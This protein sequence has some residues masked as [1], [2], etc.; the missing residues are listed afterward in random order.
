MTTFEVLVPGVE[1]LSSLTVTERGRK[2]FI[3]VKVN[4]SESCVEYY[5][6]NKWNELESDKA[7]D[8]FINFVFV[9]NIDTEFDMGQLTMSF[10]KGKLTFKI[11]MEQP[12]FRKIELETA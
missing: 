11:P 12:R 4:A 1:D 3:I 7:V 2:M 6:E 9:Y 5:R 8:E 10:R